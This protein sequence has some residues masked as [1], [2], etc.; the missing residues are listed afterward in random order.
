MPFGKQVEVLGGQRPLTFMAAA[1]TSYR[2]YNPTYFGATVRDRYPISMYRVEQNGQLLA[3]YASGGYP[4]LHLVF[5]A[6]ADGPVMI[7][8][9]QEGTE[10][11]RLDVLGPAV[12]DVGA[13]NLA[14]PLLT[15]DRVDVTGAVDYAGDAEQYRWLVGRTASYVIREETE[16]VYLN[17]WGLCCNTGQ[18]LY[19]LPLGPVTLIEGADI[20]LS[21]N[22]S[23]L[24]SSVWPPT[25]QPYRLRI[26]PWR[27]SDLAST[28]GARTADGLRTPEDLLAF[29]DAFLSDS[30]LAD[31][32]SVA[33][34]LPDGVLSADDIIVFVQDYFAP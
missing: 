32:A 6:P 21:L 22:A 3:D 16:G 20:R 8:A 7:H 30:M 29:V 26:F 9:A 4:T 25:P 15:G 19:E 1:N 18:V 27:L 28:D 13:D 10:T 12:P 31:V 5:T 11:L 17:V 14:A 2:L 33:E 34:P 24:D 23:N